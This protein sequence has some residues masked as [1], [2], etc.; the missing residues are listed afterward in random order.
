MINY[1]KFKNILFK[2]LP[3]LFMGSLFAQPTVA[4]LDFAANGFMTMKW[5]L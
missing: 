4:V 2:A 1:I 5:R 3:I